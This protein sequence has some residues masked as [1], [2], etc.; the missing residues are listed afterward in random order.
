[1]GSL[2]GEAGKNYRI[3]TG[4]FSDSVSYCARDIVEEAVKCG[5]E[6]RFK[7]SKVVRHS[8]MPGKL[9]LVARCGEG[10]GFSERPNASY[11]LNGLMPATATYGAGRHQEWKWEYGD[12]V[13]VCNMLTVDH[14]RKGANLPSDFIGYMKQFNN[15]DGFV[16]KS[17]AMG[18]G[19]RFGVAMAQSHMDTLV[20]AGVPFDIECTVGAPPGS[21]GASRVKHRFMDEA[22]WK[23]WRTVKNVTRV[24]EDF[25]HDT[26]RLQVEKKLTAFRCESERD[27]AAR[28]YVNSQ[29]RGPTM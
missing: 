18:F 25:N 5:K 29:K 24:D 27:P 6:C 22:K 14:A 15:T 2:V 23:R 4:S 28:N 21:N 10:Q 19:Q 3:P 16:F 26:K 20:K 13:G 17:I 11:Y 12:P 9:R 8:E 1:M 7:D